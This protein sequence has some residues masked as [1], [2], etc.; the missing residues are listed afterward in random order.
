MP[1]GTS[2]FTVVGTG[3]PGY[4][5]DGGQARHAALN[6]PFDVALD[7][8]GNL[9]FSDANNHCVRR[10]ERTSGVIATVAGTGTAGYSGDGGP[11]TK[12]QLH[13]PYG[14]ALDAEGNLYIVD[15]LNA[16]VRVVEVATGIIR[17]VAGTG[18]PGFSGDGGPAVQ[19][20][21]QEP[22]DI[23]LDGLGHAY[24]A[25]V[26]DHRIRVV[27]LATG[28][29][30][31]F[32]GT[33]EPGS[34][35]DGGPA[36]RAMLLGPRAL[37]FGPTGDLYICLRND[38][39]VRKVNMRTGRIH[40]VAGT[41]AKGYTGDG[42]PALQATFNGP[43][44]IAVDRHDNIFLVDTENH[45]IRRIEAAGGH[46]TTVA[47]TGQPGDSGDG[48]PAV[49]AMLKRPHGVCVDAVGNLYIGD[50]ENHRVRFVAIGEEASLPW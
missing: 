15:R 24:I 30:T 21:L 18:Q 34:G 29:I 43:K 44:E 49:H 47:G 48:G 11:A 23:V 32:A 14:I 13:S 33:G 6:Q 9:Y 28:V 31:T 35:G 22:N 4:S 20:Q 8:H 12:A 40:T 3:A 38:H 45:C 36:D 42:G 5:G 41:G 10:V 27:D 26:Q 50:S 7:R 25:D 1:A 16:C 39:K 17:T 37:A 2:I 19:A 46:V